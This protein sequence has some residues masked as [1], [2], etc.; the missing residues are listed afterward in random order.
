M[1][2]LA[3]ALLQAPGP[4]PRPRSTPKPILVVHITVDQFRAD[5]LDRWRSQLRGGLARLLRQGAVFTDAYQDHAMTETA[6]GHA[7]VLSGRN[8]R[9]TGIVR[10]DE[11]V[12]DSTAAGQLLLVT[13]PGASLAA[14]AGP[15][16]I[17]AAWG[18]VSFAVAL[19]IFRW[20]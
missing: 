11:G 15:T 1:P 7:T 14:V 10:N 2:L 8:P 12:S 4:P 9:S 6:P 18:V 17:V 16:A 13:G 20:L 19:R 3:A 5:Y